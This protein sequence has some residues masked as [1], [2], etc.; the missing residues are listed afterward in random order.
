MSGTIKHFLDTRVSSDLFVKVVLPDFTTTGK[1]RSR[2][3]RNAGIVLAIVAVSIVTY[4]PALN[5]SFISDDFTLFQMLKVLDRDPM[6]L[7]QATSEFFRLV[8]YVYFWTCFKVFGLVPEPFYWSSIALHAAMSLLVFVLVRMVTRQT[9]AGVAAAVFFA[10]YERHQEA[11]MWIS[12]A[13]EIILT[14]NCVLFLILWEYA[15]TYSR[16]RRMS[17]VLA[18]VM[19]GLA[20][21]SKEAA[22]AMVPSIVV[23]M[24]LRGYPVRVVL[25]KCWFF[26][27]M[28]AAFG[29]FWLSQANRNF[30]VTQGH[31]AL[32]FQ[33]FTVY[34]HSSLRLLSQALPFLAAFLVARRRTADKP[35]PFTALSNPSFLF[36]TL[37]ALLSIV[38]YSF[39]TYL[40]HIPSRNTYLPSIGLAGMN[41][42]LFGATWRILPSKRS[43]QLCAL[44]LSAVVAGNIAYVWLK[45]DP[46]YVER[47]APTRELI[48]VLNRSDLDWRNRIPI[49]V[50]GF[51]LHPWIGSEAVNGFTPFTD[52]E[53]LFAN[54]CNT[55][56]SGALLS[57][58]TARMTYTKI[59]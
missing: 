57:W 45:K 52:K 46:E 41:G 33:F 56:G 18:A 34:A 15:T 51:P 48:N 5:N 42:I 54:S 35:M 32:G 58:D 10:A 50:C 40:N 43:R 28:A 31:Y 47:A 22:M 17:M 21:F 12:A 16:L 59:E 11:V 44:F 27:F 9:A 29:V 7:T 20:L 39:L 30:F 37:V 25:Q 2:S 1:D 4:L 19:L 8:T 36:F 13:N 55:S 3:L 23:G 26:M 14:L 24:I 6:Y 53:V 49:T 38:P